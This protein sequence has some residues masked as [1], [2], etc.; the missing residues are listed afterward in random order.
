[1]NLEDFI[2][3]QIESV[4]DLRTLLLLHLNSQRDWDVTAVAVKLYLLPAA[5]AEILARLAAR[6][7]LVA[8]GDPV[9]YRYQPQSPELSR[10]VKEL[11]ELDR[12][13]PVTLMNLISS[14]T[15]DIQAFAN[16]FKI[17]KEN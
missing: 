10:W 6:Q 9:S 11:A 12:R 1:M 5:A 14:R 15:R 3:S 4:D 16:T 2:K 13:K 8:S 17:K 7:F